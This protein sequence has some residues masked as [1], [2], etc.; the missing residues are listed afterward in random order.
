MGGVLVTGASGFIGLPMVV[1]L[2]RRGEDVDALST[3]ASP[4]RPQACAGT[5]ST[6]WRGAPRLTS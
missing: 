5:G 1:E 3:R 6:S 2:A 4:P